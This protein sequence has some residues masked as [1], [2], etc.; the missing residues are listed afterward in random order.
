MAASLFEYI[1]DHWSYTLKWYYGMYE[2][3]GYNL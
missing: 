3:Y 2:Y 1:K